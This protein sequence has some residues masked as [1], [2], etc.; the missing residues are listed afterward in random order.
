[1][2][3]VLALLCLIWPFALAAQDA[4][5]DRGFLIGLLES[6]LGGEGRTVRIDGFAGVLSSTATIEQI[7]VADTEGVWL[8]LENVAIN[9]NR[10]A[11]FRGAIDISELS[12]ARVDLPRLPVVA[13]NAAPAPE[14]TPFA[15]PD[16][17]A[18]LQI[19]QMR[20]DRVSLGAPVLGEAA[21]FALS[22]AA[23]LAGG[24]G[25]AT[26]Q[27]QRLDGQ[28][29]SFDVLARYANDTRALTLDL[30][31]QEAAGG[32]ISGLLNVPDRPSVDLK[33]TGDG[34]LSD[35]AAQLDLRTDDTPRLAGALQLQSEADGPMAFDVDLGGDVTALFLPQYADFF[36]PDVQLTAAGNQDGNG[37][38]TLDTFDLRTRVLQLAGQAA[39]NPDGWPTLLDVTGEIEDPTGTSVL[40]PVSGDDTRIDRADLSVQ[41]DASDGDALTAR[42]DVRGLDRVDAQADALVM[43]LNGTLSGDVNAIGSVETRIA[44]AATGLG[45]SD[46]ALARAVGTVVRGNL[47]VTYT[48]AMPLR[49]GDMALT[50]ADWA[51][52]GDATID[53]F[54]DAFRTEFDVALDTPDLT[55]F[56]D[57]AGLDLTGAGTLS[58]TGNAAL[59][60]FF[61]VAVAGET[62]DLAIGIAQADALLTGATTLD[63]AARRDE[64]GTYLDRLMLENEA[65]S[66]DVTAT[67]QTGA[68]TARYALRLDDA[69]RV[70]DAVSGPLTIDGTAQQSGD[71][72]DVAAALAGPLAASA[73]VEATIA[74]ARTEIDLKAALPDIAQLVPQVQ[75]SALV[76]A[77]AVQQDGVWDFTSDT[78]GPYSSTATIS[79]RF[80]DNTLSAD[81]SVA[82]PNIAP[83]APGVSGPIA[84]DGN[85]QQMADGWEFGTEFTGPYTS[86]GTVSGAYKAAKLTA[87]FDVG[88]PNVAP[89]APGI[90]GPLALNGTV[91]QTDAGWAV[92]T[93]IEGPYRST[94][95]LSGTYAPDNL[96][97]RYA[98]QLPNVGAL[99]PQLNGAASVT[100]TAQQVPR[101]FDIAADLTGPAGT[102]ARVAGLVGSDGQ[103]ALDANG[104]AQLGLANPFIEPRN[105]AGVANFDLTVDGPPALSSV[106]GQITTQGT[107]LAAPNLPLSFDDISGAVRLNGG[108]AVI[109]ITAGVTEG[110]AI[111][112]DGPITLSGGYPAQ[113]DVG[114]NA[115]TVTDGAIYTSTLD[116]DVSLRGA[117]TGGAR[118]AGTVNVG[119]TNVQIPASGIST[120]GSIP[121][122]THIGATRPVMRTRDRAGLT[123]S[124]E[125]T[126]NGVAFPLDITINAP[127]RIFV[128]GRGLDA[129][130][131]GSLRL[132]GTSA[133]TISTGQFDL[134]RGRLDIL[135]KRFDL[136]E[137]I[138]RL[139]GRFDPYLRFVVAT[140][141]TTGTARIVVDGP[142]DDPQVTFEATPEAPQDQVLAQIFFGRD[143]SQL[144]AFQA[145]QLASAVASLAGAGGEGI[146]SRLRGSFNLD[147]LDV[148][149]DT[150]G[151]TAVRAGKYIS[152]NIYTDVTVGG[153]DGPEVSLNIDLTPNVTVRGSVG[154]DS[155]T[156]LG[157][158]IE[159]DY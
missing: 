1:M 155:N 63:M 49:L 157:I 66:A 114:L 127:S 15:L 64:T 159:K 148:T 158:F 29:A 153:A 12:A 100:G 31:L 105:I 51:V 4:D 32:L 45:L 30:D 117:L 42:V 70:T 73:D 110:G 52:R 50:G 43:Q 112:I 14:A 46:P 81:Y 72:W 85:V 113:I 119:E 156:G 82:L 126:G 146:V 39:L 33:I 106:N 65:L 36:G 86:A 76:T 147:D 137:G 144:S 25:D 133:D 40:L 87:A 48:E 138:V 71:V 97:A 35:F 13:P 78:K 136:D 58:A 108:Q 109:D 55:A 90:T 143:I 59:G 101:G 98:L 128:R 37:A 116:G 17:P 129:E 91:R 104:Q 26:L 74:P 142:A 150:D 27:A 7:T 57:L 139:Q 115:V 96:S 140:T 89:L 54:S 28:A 83:L 41:F 92:D 18:S 152:E 94:G 10:S 145:L 107:R 93:D 123:A 68:S 38:L 6:S 111:D 3:C 23:S 84:L 20:I 88:L 75:G 103:L 79:G 21:A 56:A 47:S 130:L 9:W 67:L 154:A 99:V 69:G 80:A 120:F 132:T 149:T 19:G 61:D 44:L 95:T 125:S 141:T 77:N 60:G 16:L 24:A 34:V 135:A 8:T 62:R 5:E 118:I 53:S 122:I 102:T 151:N 134:I 121:D 131:G 11:L 22:G 2:R 124:T